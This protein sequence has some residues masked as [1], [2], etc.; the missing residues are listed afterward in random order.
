MTA[1]RRD[2]I[3]YSPCQGDSADPKFASPLRHPLSHLPGDAGRRVQGPIARILLISNCLRFI[4]LITYLFFLFTSNS[5]FLLD[6][7]RKNHMIRENPAVFA[8]LSSFVGVQ[9]RG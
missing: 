4:P 6:I 7:G 9:G 3:I 8:A 2:T 5:Y 1:I